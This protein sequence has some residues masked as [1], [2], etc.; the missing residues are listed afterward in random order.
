MPAKEADKKM[1][2][3]IIQAALAETAFTKCQDPKYDRTKLDIKALKAVVSVLGG[4]VGK[5]VKLKA[6]LLEIAL[7]LL[8]KRFPVTTPG[9]SLA[10][11]AANATGGSTG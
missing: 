10:T 7:P 9:P 6:D 3:D 11:V 8:D 1:R 4:T 2:A 5:D